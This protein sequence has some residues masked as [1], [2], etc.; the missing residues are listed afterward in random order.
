M[1]IQ[2]YNLD[3]PPNY[4]DFNLQEFHNFVA[5]KIEDLDPIINKKR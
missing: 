4:K 5:Q 3:D 1:A 2:T